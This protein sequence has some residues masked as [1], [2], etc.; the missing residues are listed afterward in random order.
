MLKGK[1]IVIGV[2]GSI[3]AYKVAFLIRILKKENAEVKVVTTPSA[4]DFVSPL[5]LSVLSENPVWSAFSNPLDGTWNNHVDLALWADVMVIAPASANTLSKMAH[6]AC[7]N[8]LMAVYL[9][10][11][12]PVLFAPAMDLDM[13][14]HPATQE[15]IVKLRSFGNVFVPPGKG[16]LASG[17]VGE[18]RMAEPEEIAEFIRTQ[19]VEKT[20]LGKKALVNAG[21]TQ[22]AIDPVRFIG[23]RSSGKMG[24]A[25][26]E[27]LARRGASVTL[28]MGPSEVQSLVPGIERINVI[29]AEDMYEQCV[30][31]FKSCDIAVMAAAV[32]DY[33]PMRSAAQK[34][35]K[36]EGDLLLSL[37][38]TKDILAH[39]G[40]IKGAEQVL[41]GFALETEHGID[42]AKE[43]V[44]KKNAD[45]IVL[46]SLST[47]NVGFGAE[48]NQVQFVDNNLH[49]ESFAS[50]LKSEVAADIVH[51]ISG[52]VKSKT[53]K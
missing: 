9:S 14:K 48:V 1:K 23:N 50:K 24:M 49:V 42:Y 7:D 34:I 41:V 30:Q 35:K 40:T 45:F 4:F 46:N 21:P 51:K 28:V 11:K 38:K 19:V 10:A 36:N 47:S 43:K 37:T 25:I 39:L 33:T 17:L 29:S 52:I 22:E 8:L 18:G 2:T 44:I 3:A 5:T 32:A 16:A 27:E 13:Y 31:V 12:C 26:A 15:N 53:E 6:G 20:L